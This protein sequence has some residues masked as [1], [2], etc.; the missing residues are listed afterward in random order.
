MSNTLTRRKE[1]VEREPAENDDWYCLRVEPWRCGN[2]GG[3]FRYHMH[4]GYNGDHL[5][6]VWP[7][8]DDPNMY[9]AIGERDGRAAIVPFEDTYGPAI[10]F[11]AIRP[12]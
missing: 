9:H 3:S 10:S 8:R 1:H 6:I 12:S 2:C 7:G 4:G 5:V 11:Y